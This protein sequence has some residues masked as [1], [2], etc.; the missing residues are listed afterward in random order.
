MQQSVKVEL[1]II[2]RAAKAL[3]LT[4]PPSLLARADEVIE[5]F[6]LRDSLCCTRSGLFPGTHCPFAALQRFRLFSEDLLPYT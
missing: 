5:S 4:I 2:L 6:H 3:G 1:V